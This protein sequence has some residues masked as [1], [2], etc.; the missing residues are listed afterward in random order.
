MENV[1]QNRQIGEEELKSLMLR[2]R[3]TAPHFSL[4]CQVER[5]RVLLRTAVEV[6]TICRRREFKETDEIRENINKVAAW[7]CAPDRQFF[8]LFCGG[9]GNGKTTFLRAIETVINSSGVINSWRKEKFRM[10]NLTVAQIH[11]SCRAYLN[12]QNYSP[13]WTTIQNCDILGIDDLGMESSEIQVYGNPVRPI[14]ELLCYRYEKQLMTL[15]SSNLPAKD[16][17]ERYGRRLADRLREVALVIPF[18]DESFRNPPN[19]K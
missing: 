7:L 1:N 17:S 9:C 16:I 14:E 3:T 11:A 12:Y 5:A 19:A 10:R 6:E 2:L 8:I 18:L 4:P 13:D 15:M